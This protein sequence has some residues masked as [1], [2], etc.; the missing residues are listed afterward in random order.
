MSN[1]TYVALDNVA[2]FLRPSG[3]PS[4]NIADAQVF[5]HRGDAYAHC[6][7]HGFE[8]RAKDSNGE[9]WRP[10]NELMCPK[11]LGLDRG[12]EECDMCHGDY[13]GYLGGG[14]NE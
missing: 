14:R 7:K 13:I 5:T 12:L 9:H 10:R 6:L 8:P 2:Y 1:V 4:A 11:C 3:A